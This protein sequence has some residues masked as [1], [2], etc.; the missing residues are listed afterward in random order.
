M[1]LIQLNLNHCRTA[2]DLLTQTVREVG[3]E[4]AILSE[5]YRTGTSRD[6][7][8]VL[9][10]FAALDITLLNEGTQQTFNRAGAGSIID[11]TY[12]SSSL[13]R[14]ARWRISDIDTESDHEAIL[15]S[16]RKGSAHRSTPPLARK[17]YR[18]DTLSVPACAAALEDLNLTGMDCA[19]DAASKLAADTERARDI[20]MQQR[21]KYRKH[22]QPVFWWNEEIA[23]LRASCLRLRRPR[24]LQRQVQDRQEG[25]QKGH[26]SE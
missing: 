19:N 4:V 11:L 9:E 13:A 3:T 26:K 6:G 25:P 16:I 22:H 20:S 14:Q 2:Q 24:R 12:A 18:Q 21:K 17:A 23:I 15:V 8:V 7:R 10:A 1:Q 5:P